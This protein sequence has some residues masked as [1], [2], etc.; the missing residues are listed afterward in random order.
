MTGAL[1]TARGVAE[2]LGV[3]TETVLRWSR[4]GTLP[5]IRLPSGALRYR[6]DALE[7][8]LAE[9][10]TPMSGTTAQDCPS[11]DNAPVGNGREVT[12]LPPG[13]TRPPV[14]ANGTSRDGSLT[15]ST[16]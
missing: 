8:W 16:S 14:A 12:T 9:R 11:N 10:A 15:T 5:G 1:M 2:C 7:A 6:A 3:S 4:R 13:V